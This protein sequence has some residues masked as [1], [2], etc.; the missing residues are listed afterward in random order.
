MLAD[1]IDTEST[2]KLVEVEPCSICLNDYTEGDILCWSQNSECQHAFHKDCA[3]E[4]LMQSTKCPLCRSNYL[5]L[6]GDDELSPQDNVDDHDAL[7]I[8][9][10]PAVLRMIN[11]VPADDTVTFLRSMHLLY[12]LSQLQATSDSPTENPPQW[13]GIELTTGS[14]RT[15]RIQ[16]EPT[17][18]VGGEPGSERQLNSFDESESTTRVGST[19]AGNEADDEPV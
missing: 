17:I 19:S 13:Q 14:F 8:L 2:T 10:I 3:M 9:T 7:P 4:W 5:S 16:E 1:V 18:S 11:N 6:D 12:L 15:G